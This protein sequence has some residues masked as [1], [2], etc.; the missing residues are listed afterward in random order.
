MYR[1]R[2]VK[3]E[4]PP[5]PD[6]LEDFGYIV[7]E[8]H[9][10][11]HKEEGTPYDFEFLY[12][13]RPY[14][15]AR[16]EAFIELI[17][18][19]V[20]ERLQQSPLNFQKTIVPVGADPAKNDKYTYVYMTPNALTTTDKLLLLIPGI[21]TRIGQWS[22]RIMCDENVERGSM[23][24]ISKLAQSEG[25]E[26]I[27]FNPNGLFFYDNA[28]HD[29]V[30]SNTPFE[31]IP[32][33]SGPEEHCQYVFEQF[34]RSSKAKTVNVIALGWGG[35][36]FTEILNKHFDFVKER[37]GAVAI[38]DSAHSIT[39]V[40]GEHKRAWMINHMANW[41]VSGEPKGT[42]IRDP[43]MGCDTISANIEIADFTLP[44]CLDEI[45]R[46]VG[47]KT[48]DV[49]ANEDQSSEMPSK[50]ELE[51]LDDRVQMLDL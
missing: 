22:R 38:A 45:L 20:E 36:C 44:T 32:E 19:M 11:R 24:E 5:I 30:L 31:I 9:E 28:P 8:N 46:Y 42:I 14:N 6:K 43:R 12:K 3:E 25:F 17:G 18:D 7:N 23:I 35:Y 40:E 49:V 34:V 48:G 51:E 41:A 29:R 13:N 27:I 2:K 16:Y 50:E 26:V 39:L 10:I 37:V 21:K 15:E 4:L 1:R 47:I 33:N